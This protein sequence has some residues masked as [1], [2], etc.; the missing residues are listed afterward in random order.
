LT[1]NFGFT[2]GSSIFYP[3]S[4]VTASIPAS[5]SNTAVAS[6]LQTALLANAL[7][8]TY[9]NVYVSGSV[10]T[11]QA[12]DA[13]SYWSGTPN[14]TFVWSSAPSSGC[15]PSFVNTNGINNA[16]PNDAN[17]Y[18]TGL[19]GGY[20]LICGNQY[21]Q[22]QYINGDNTT[23]RDL[24]GW[25][26]P[27]TINGFNVVSLTASVIRAY[28]NQLIAGNITYLLSNGTIV[29]RPSTVLIS[30]ISA[31]GG[32]PSTWQ[33]TSANA[34][35]NFEL[36]ASDSIVD[37]QIL[38]NQA[39]VFCQNSIFAV[40][41]STALSPTPVKIL[42]TTRGA[43]SK[44]CALVVDGLIYF[45]A[46]DDILVSDGTS[47]NWKSIANDI[48]KQYF[49]QTEL[50]VNGGNLVRLYY[51][52]QF[53]EITMLYPSASGT[54][55]VCDKAFTYDVEDKSWTSTDLSNGLFTGVLDVTYGPVNGNNDTYRPWSNTI[56]SN[57]FYRLHFIQGSRLWAM[58]VGYMRN[59][60][61]GNPPVYQCQLVKF[62]DLHS[63][64][65]A[66]D[67]MYTLNHVWPQ[68]DC[69]TTVTFDF[70]TYATTVP[71]GS[72]DFSA[73]D[74]T[75]TFDGSKSSYPDY[76][77]S[78]NVRGRY[79]AMRITMPVSDLVSLSGITL[80]VTPSKA[81]Y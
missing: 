15:V 75:L 5:S 39:I 52:R 67:M 68:L 34:A 22:P 20:S 24:P 25:N 12:K 31:P 76:K 14:F 69:N 8:N 42:N 26:Y 32:I 45:V 28:G 19:N 77:I 16:L 7:I 62:I 17:W 81:F 70:K 63:P 54:G 59:D 71:K 50:Y 2:G 58:D 30:D 38:K 44:D 36:S 9:F 1:I 73:P 78:P 56:F 48:I 79:L 61:S 47:T 65:D 53:N 37:I 3:A 41:Q 46:Q 51:N 64:N 29:R 66:L 43:L 60:L 57:H 35:D 27:Q 33:V 23:L 10:V 40:G 72:I 4:V 74:A 80:D 13:G 11:V 55:S 6:I 21:I 18:A 49:F